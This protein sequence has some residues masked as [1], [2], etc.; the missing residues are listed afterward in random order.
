M[1]I[2]TSTP[3]GGLTS[4]NM[5]AKVYRAGV[6]NAADTGIDIVTNF[7]VLV[8]VKHVTLNPETAQYIVSKVRVDRIIIVCKEKESEQISLAL[9]G[10]GFWDRIQAVITEEKLNE[11]YKRCLSPAYVDAIGR[12]IIKTIKEEFVM[13]FPFVRELSRFLE[14]RGYDPN[15]LTGRWRL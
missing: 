10:A 6:A 3:P 12:N 2:L 14:E 11:W 7:G 15:R 8:Q 4:V 13:E 5:E 9:K 1:R